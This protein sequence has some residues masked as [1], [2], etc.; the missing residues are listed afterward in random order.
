M[1][2]FIA[3][4]VSCSFPEF[5]IVLFAAIALTNG[6]SHTATALWDGGYGPGLFVSAV[7][8]IPMGVAALVMMF[9]RMPAAR[10]AIAAA[11]GIAINVAVG[12]IAMRGGKIRRNALN[13]RPLHPKRPIPVTEEKN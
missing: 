13:K 6:V 8:W 4:S 2:A 7:I 1:L 3:I 10:F 12:V 5:A 11:I 9:G